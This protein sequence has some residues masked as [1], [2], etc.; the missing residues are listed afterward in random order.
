MIINLKYFIIFGIALCLISSMSSVEAQN[1]E[2]KKKL[3]EKKK[4]DEKKNQEDAFISKKYQMIPPCRKN[5]FTK[6]N[7]M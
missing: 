7:Q 3:E 4:P 1:E 2:E 5:S 6:M